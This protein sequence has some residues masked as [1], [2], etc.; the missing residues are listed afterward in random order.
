[1]NKELRRLFS[2]QWVYDISR[3][4][5][6]WHDELTIKSNYE[7]FKK[8]KLPHFYYA[9]I[10]RSGH[11]DFFHLHNGV[12]NKGK[13]VK[14]LRKNFANKNYIKFLE[15][16]YYKK[17]EE[18]V[19][20]SKKLTVDY[21]SFKNYFIS[22]GLMSPTLD[23][24]ATGSKLI[25]DYL[26]TELADRPN[27]TDIIAYY[28]QMKKKS[29]LQKMEAELAQ[30][31]KNKQNS[32][33]LA[34]TLYKKYC[35]IPV[36]FIGEPWRLEYFTKKVKQY[37]PINHHKIPKPA[38][39]VSKRL[40]Y[41]L[42]LLGQIAY[43]NEYRKS[44]FSRCNYIIRP[45]LDKIAKQHKLGTW[46]DL[47]LLASNEIL[48]LLKGN[49]DY[50][51]EMIKSRRGDWL[52]YS[53]GKKGIGYVHG[54][55]VLKFERKFKP[56]IKGL[57]EVK[58][59]VANKGYVKGTVKV[60]YEPKD[61]GKFKPGDVLVAKMTSVDF[62]PI[63]KKAAAFVTNEGGLACHAAIVSR[64]INIPCVIG[65]MNAT[66]AFKDGDRVEV[67]ANKGLVRKL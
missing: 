8:L 44:V 38:G 46:K 63:M 3:N 45:L 12:N 32:K 47:N 18:L 53:V 9:R 36:S 10:N 31:V 57:N 1:M 22:Y 43:L 66:D 7:G 41:Y 5:Q 48:D 29:P 59:T 52:M 55:A 27:R 65:T 64:E 20:L 67:D 51:K 56:T 61:F 11:A 54:Q 49:D 25:T 17:G 62:V 34:K 2:Q 40:M 13:F 19:Q 60:I 37:K 21:K 30:G 42:I 33:K 14:A 50:Q 28:S 26:L 39:R 58:G 15:K 6:F 4:I 35:W 16:Y 24:T 23:T